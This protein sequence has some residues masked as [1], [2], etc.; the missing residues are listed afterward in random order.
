MNARTVM[1]LLLQAWDEEG[2]EID[3][4]DEII[5]AV[6]VVHGGTDRR[7]SPTGAA[8]PETPVE[9]TAGAEA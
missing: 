8:E 1:N 4:T 5:G 7:S 2:F 3:L 6:A 9:S